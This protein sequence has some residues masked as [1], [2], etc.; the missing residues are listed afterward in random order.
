MANDLNKEIDQFAIEVETTISE[1]ESFLD[2]LPEF[3]PRSRR[4]KKLRRIA[5]QR[6]R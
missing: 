2:S 1:T 5:T 3:A 6:R 4:S